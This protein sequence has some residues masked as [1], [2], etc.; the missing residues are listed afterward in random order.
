MYL[1]DQT[2]QWL[3]SPGLSKYFYGNNWVYLKKSECFCTTRKTSLVKHIHS[4][5]REVLNKITL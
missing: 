1:P 4:K 3:S 5:H 2:V